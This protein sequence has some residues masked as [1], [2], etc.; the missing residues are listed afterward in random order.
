[1][2]GRVTKAALIEAAALKA[3]KTIALRREA[4]RL[5]ESGESVPNIASRLGISRASVKR[6]LERA[7]AE[8]PSA[9]GDSAAQEGTAGGRDGSTLLP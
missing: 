2:S 6:L 9:G 5:R 7:T 8:P 1:M 4:R 3:R